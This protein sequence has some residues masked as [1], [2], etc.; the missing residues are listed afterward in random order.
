[1]Y[2]HLGGDKSVNINDIVALFDMD[3]TTISARGRKFLNEAGR[4]GEIVDVSD[5]L[6]KSY[7]VTESG[8]KRV[9]YISSLAPQTLIKRAT[10][11]K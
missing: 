5:D 10:Q 11:K 7:I 3:N 4:R 1:M 2:L 8:G 9:V 6:P